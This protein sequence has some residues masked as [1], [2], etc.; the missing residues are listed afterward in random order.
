MSRMGP[1]GPT[2]VTLVSDLSLNDLLW[3]ANTG[4]GPAATGTPGCAASRPT[5][6]T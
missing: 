6:I 2:A 5:T 4:H 3:V 1:R